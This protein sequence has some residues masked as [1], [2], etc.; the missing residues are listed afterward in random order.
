[1]TRS[2]VRRN[3]LL[4][5]VGMACLSGL[6][7]LVAA[8]S[9]ITFV[10][11]SGVESLIGLGAALVL[12]AWALTSF[13]AG[14]AMDRRGRAPVLLV[15]FAGGA[16]GAALVALAVVTENAIPAV[17]GFALIGAA[18]A[19]VNLSRTAAGDMYPPAHRA[20]GIAFVIFGSVFGAILGPAVFSPLLGEDSAGTGTLAVGWVAGGGIM[21]LGFAAVSFVRLPRPSPRLDYE[22][23]SGGVSGDIG[24]RAAR[25]IRVE[26]DGGGSE[27]PISELL[28]RPGVV[29]ALA[30][31][32][33]SFAVM[34]AVM[35]LSGQVV[36]G[37]GHERHEVF[38]VISAHIV[39]M[40]GLALV[41]G[42][43]VDRIGRP[44]ALAG[45]LLLVAFSCASLAWVVSI[46]AT[47]V[48]LFGL[49]LGWSFSYVAAT[50]QLS[51][52]T[53]EAERGRI[54]GF[55]DA[56]SAGTGA[57]FALAGGYTLSTAGVAVLGVG[58][59]A[60][61]LAPVSYYAASAAL[62]P[63]RA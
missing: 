56:L 53:V 9:A 62:R 3:T 6:L 30:A 17:P 63:A 7:Q 59:A 58:A 32:V 42:Q 18:N 40:F 1:M 45:G 35:N 12:A 46:P 44:V 11:V 49:G 55:S 57:V 5:A 13:P 8:L 41:V 47:A 52:A 10:A 39:G 28:Q 14:R 48:A 38:P 2:L 36:V 33:A 16:A 23:P 43:I 50:A 60:I 34:V 51:D 24:G 15:G 25:A 37:H 27:T 21:L 19:I 29:P 31:A 54:L 20:R 61:A 4:L 22:G 26:E